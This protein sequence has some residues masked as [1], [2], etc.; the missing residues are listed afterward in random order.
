MRISV[1]ADTIDVLRYRQPEHLDL[2]VQ[3]HEPRVRL[4]THLGHIMLAREQSRH[5]GCLASIRPAA[6]QLKSA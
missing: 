1:R 3:L 2:L 4:Q 5:I 6:L